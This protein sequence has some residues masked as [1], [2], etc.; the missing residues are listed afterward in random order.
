MTDGPTPRLLWT[1]LLLLAF[2]RRRAQQ[3]SSLCLA[4]CRRWCACLHVHACSLVAAADDR[5]AS[6]CVCVCVCF[7]ALDDGD[8]PAVAAAETAAPTTQLVRARV[9]VSQRCGTVA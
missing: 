5:S 9:P 2:A 1:T 8:Q 4:C 3:R 6:R 7:P